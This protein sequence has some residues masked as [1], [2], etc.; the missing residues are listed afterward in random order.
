MNVLW[1]FYLI[2]II[3]FVICVDRTPVSEEFAG[4]Y[5]SDEEW[6]GYI[7]KNDRV[8]LKVYFFISYILSI[9]VVAMTLVA[10]LV[11]LMISTK[12]SNSG[13]PNYWIIN[14]NK[15]KKKKSIDIVC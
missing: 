4:G 5:P 10:Q 3:V 9:N 13:N 15:K 11:P 7:N 8:L 6:H 2:L 14:N 1:I 12:T